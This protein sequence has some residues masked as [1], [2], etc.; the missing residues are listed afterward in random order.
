MKRSISGPQSGAETSSMR[1]ARLGQR[2]AMRRQLLESIAIGR[3]SGYSTPVLTSI[4]ILGRLYALEGEFE[5]ALRQV[6][7]ALGLARQIES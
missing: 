2:Q 3:E 5:R 4:W 6:D 7:G 1:V